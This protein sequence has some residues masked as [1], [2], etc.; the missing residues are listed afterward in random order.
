MGERMSTSQSTTHTSHADPRRDDIIRLLDEHDPEGGVTPDEDC[1]PEAARRDF[2]GPQ[3]DAIL[4]F[5]HA[6]APAD[7]APDA[8]SMTGQIRGLTFEDGEPS[9]PSCG[10]EDCECPD[11]DVTA[12]PAGTYLTIRLD[13][14]PAVGFWPVRIERIV[15]AE[16]HQEVKHHAR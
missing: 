7:P 4:A 13:G 14:E 15:A 2:W 10:L 12:P 6:T 11:H 8:Q 16:A 1:D 9:E 5:L 3:A